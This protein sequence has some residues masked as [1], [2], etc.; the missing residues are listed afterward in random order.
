MTPASKNDR[1]RITRRSN[2]AIIDRAL[3]H[4][5]YGP[6]KLVPGAGFDPAAIPLCK[7]GGFDH[8]HHPGT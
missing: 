4:L 3:C 5:S 8:S 6:Q 7:R 1:P 2:L